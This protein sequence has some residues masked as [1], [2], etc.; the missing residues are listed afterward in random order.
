MAGDTTEVIFSGGRWPHWY[1]DGKIL[2]QDYDGG[3]KIKLAEL[4]EGM[5]P[6]NPNKWSFRVLLD[7]TSSNI[8]YSDPFMLPGGY[9]EFI[10]TKKNEHLYNT[11]HDNSDPNSYGYGCVAYNRNSGEEKDALKEEQNHNIGHCYGRSENEY[12]GG[13]D[14]YKPDRFVK[15]RAGNWVVSNQTNGAA[16]RPIKKGA[17]L[18]AMGTDDET[19]NSYG[20]DYC[21]GNAN[22]PQNGRLYYAYGN[23]CLGSND[24]NYLIISIMC[25]RDD[26]ADGHNDSSA[27]PIETEYSRTFLIDVTNLDN[28]IYHDITLA[29]EK[30]LGKSSYSWESY[31]GDCYEIVND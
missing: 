24:S 1:A 31:G 13:G 23:F 16:F 11:E 21:A 30:N 12:W 8:T 15:T 5:D 6:R 4:I 2:F 19:K 18:A 20:Q 17:E 28:A 7:N 22:N 3:Q 14:G 29:V 26:D 27:K 9:N 25:G 10:A